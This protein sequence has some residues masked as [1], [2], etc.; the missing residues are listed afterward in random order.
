MLLIIIIVSSIATRGKGLSSNYYETTCPQAEAIVT[1]VVNKA[2]MADTTVPAG[3]LRMHFHDCFIRGC[4]ASVL[5]ESKN[6]NSPAEKNGPPNVSLH[7]F[8]VVDDA[9]KAVEAICPGVVSC[10]DILAFAARDA[11]VAAGGPYWEVPKGRKDGRVSKASET[12]QL[13]APAFNLSQLYLSFSLR[14]LSMEDLVALSGGHTIGFSHCSS[15]D[16]RLRN[17][18]ATS[19]VDPTLNRAMAAQLRGICPPGGNSKNAGTGMDPSSTTF[20]NN[21]YKLLLQGKG[22]FSSDQALLAN[23][24]T[25]ALVLQYASS[26]EAFFKAFA[27]SMIKMSSI[28]GGEGVRTDCRVSN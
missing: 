23:P 4:D 21:Y 15:F 8:F 3:L 24:K 18:N 20:D 27:N 9:K 13:P 22:L 6:K 11:V 2:S 19:D 14:G 7:A 17:F 26:Q 16:N 5:L 12:I 28:T 10:A 25:R 1:E